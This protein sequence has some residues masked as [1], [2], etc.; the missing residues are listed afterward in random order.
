[1]MRMVQQMLILV[2]TLSLTL[3]IVMVVVMQMM[4]IRLTCT[5][6]GAGFRSTRIHRISRTGS[7]GLVKA[8]TSRR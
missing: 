3:M 5:T 6:G 2:L 1:M 7:T 4:M 8:R